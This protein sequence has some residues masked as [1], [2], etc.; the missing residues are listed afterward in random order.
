MT[1]PQVL[2]TWPK[3]GNYNYSY[4]KNKK[5]SSPMC[6]PRWCGHVNV[7]SVGNVCVLSSHGWNANI[8]CTR[9]QQHKSQIRNKY[10]RDKKHNTASEKEQSTTDARRSLYVCLSISAWNS[11]TFDRLHHYNTPNNYSPPFRVYRALPPVFPCYASMFACLHWM[12]IVGG[13]GFLGGS[14]PVGR[15]LKTSP[16]SLSMTTLDEYRGSKYWEGL[17]PSATAPR[18]WD[19]GFQSFLVKYVQELRVALTYP[20][21]NP[22]GMSLQ[23]Y[24]GKFCL[25]TLSVGLYRTEE[26]I[27]IYLTWSTSMY[28]TMR[29]TYI[30]TYMCT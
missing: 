21:P 26:Y 19:E 27:R 7:C 20:N 25:W 13:E 8:P 30:R 18:K 28:D 24:H 12:H 16:S 14:L 6:Y 9:T 17:V 15:S 3:L 4:A 29:R 2:Q 5:K 22:K 10:E 1:P 23:Y 11:Q